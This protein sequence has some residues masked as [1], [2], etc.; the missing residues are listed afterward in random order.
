MVNHHKITEQGHELGGG[1]FLLSWFSAWG[2][3]TCLVFEL[4]LAF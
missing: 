4:L 1:G 2:W 3:Q